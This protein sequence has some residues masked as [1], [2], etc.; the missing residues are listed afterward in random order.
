MENKFFY[1][2]IDKFSFDS[3]LQNTNKSKVGFYSVGLYPAS[4]AYNC[5]MHS[6]ELNILL[7]PRPGRE[8]FG[9]F[10]DDVLS[11]MDPKLEN[12]G[13]LVGVPTSDGTQGV[14]TVT[15]AYRAGGWPAVWDCLH[16]MV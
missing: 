15:I 12:V 8:L 14:I 13:F 4:L 5:A 11:N 9:A 7:A 16:S 10:S 2:T 6:R 3:F 1:G